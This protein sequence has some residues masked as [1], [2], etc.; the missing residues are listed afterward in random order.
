VTHLLRAT[1]LR[2]LAASATALGSDFGLF[3][4]MLSAGLPASLASGVGYSAGIVAHWWLSSRAVFA[5]GLAD[6]GGERR[7]QQGLFLLT[8]LAGLACTMSVVGVG[9]G[10]GLDPRLAKVTA[11]M[12]SFQL[13]WL[14]RRHIVFAR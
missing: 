10:L 1:Y 2:Y 12:L 5:G 7:R 11:I 3:L 6:A 9:A 13:V 8:A 4:L 14:L